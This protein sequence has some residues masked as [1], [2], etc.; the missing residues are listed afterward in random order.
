MQPVKALTVWVNVYGDTT[1]QK[2]LSFIWFNETK[3]LYEFYASQRSLRQRQ[4]DIAWFPSQLNREDLFA[5][6]ERM[7]SSLLWHYISSPEH[8]VQWKFQD[9]GV[10]K[11]SYIDRFANGT[12]TRLG[13]AGCLMHE[14]HTAACRIQ[15]V[16]RG[17]R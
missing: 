12:S 1:E 7:N 17:I 14:T 8:I 4:T 9:Y 16:W 15:R 10:A 2:C 5:Y 11:W 6:F 3:T 13:F